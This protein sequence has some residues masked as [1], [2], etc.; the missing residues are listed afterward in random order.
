MFKGK[1][2]FD[3]GYE[4]EDRKQE[5]GVK[6]WSKSKKTTKNQKRDVRRWQNQSKRNVEIEQQ[7][8]LVMLTYMLDKNKRYVHR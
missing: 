8:V 5:Y 6:A 7:D 3:A 2:P 1:S 4:K